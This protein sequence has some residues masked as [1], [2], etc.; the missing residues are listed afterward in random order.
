MDTAFFIALGASFVLNG[1]I[2]AVFNWMSHDA[3]FNRYRIRIP[4]SPQIPPLRKWL[5]V[6]LNGLFSTL[7][8]FAFLYGFGHQVIVAGPPASVAAFVGETLGVLLLY[9]FMYYFLHRFMH[10]RLV[11]KYVHRTHHLIRFPTAPESIYLHPAENF[12]GI[13]LLLLAV[14]LFG[15]V[16][17]LSFIIVWFVYSIVNVL[18][19]TNFVFPHPAFRLFNF[20]TTKHDTH[21]FRMTYNYASIFPFW[22]QAFGTDK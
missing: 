5:N 15:P 10:N 17:G 2:M 14:S 13:G 11:L 7:L 6:S 21:H 9:D 4:K 20:W 8:L 18:V 1:L 3:R 19:H 16:S 12:A 22:D